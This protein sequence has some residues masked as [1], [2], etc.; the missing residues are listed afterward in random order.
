MGRGEECLGYVYTYFRWW[1]CD[2]SA[3]IEWR[4]EDQLG[5]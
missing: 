3:G 2:L 1:F 5:V 4:K